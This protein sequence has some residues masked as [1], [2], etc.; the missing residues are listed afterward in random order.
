MDSTTNLIIGAGITGLSFTASCVNEDYIIIEKENHPGGLCNTIYKD[1]FIWDYSGHF[2]HF[3]ESDI[4]KLII[5]NLGPDGIIKRQKKTQIYYNDQTIDYPFQMNIHQLNKPEFIDCLY[6]LYVT[7][8]NL[9]KPSS[10]KEMIISRYGNSISN[11]FLIPYNEKLYACDLDSLDKDALGRFFPH[12]D[13]DEIIRNIKNEK[14]SSYNSTYY[15]PINGSLK[16]IELYL[17]KIK[18][19]SIYYNETVI[20]IDIKN[21]IATTNKREIKYSNLISTIP[22]P[23]LLQASGIE[24]SDT[25]LRANKV[26]VF[27]FGFDSASNDKE[28]HW[29]YFP[30]KKFIFYRVGYYNNINGTDKMSLYVEIGLPDGETIDIEY[31]RKCVIRDLGVAGVVTTQNITAEHNVIIDPAYV[32]ISADSENFKKKVFQS[33]NTSDIYSIGRYGAWKYCSIEDNIIESYELAHTLNQ[34]SNVSG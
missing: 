31:Y 14:N 29:I 32:H 24:Y 7:K 20:N 22:L 33:L 16:I 3:K 18:M 12:A 23:Y 30:D 6:D 27:N 10:F 21:K 26:L 4:E 15:Y 34:I 9:E 5:S 1:G 2:L 17:S 28:N 25:I 8:D 13:V 19:D 11:K